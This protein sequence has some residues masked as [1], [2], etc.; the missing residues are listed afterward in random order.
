MSWRLVSGLVV[1]HG[2]NRARQRDNDLV[3]QQIG[4]KI[5]AT[6]SLILGPDHPRPLS[7][8]PRCVVTKSSESDRI[9]AFPSIEL[10]ARV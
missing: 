7:F 9:F 1:R 8:G 4:L 5:P 6:H 3:T 2:V 10:M